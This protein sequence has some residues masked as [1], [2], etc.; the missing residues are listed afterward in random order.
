MNDFEK[1]NGFKPMAIE[2]E[3]GNEIKSPDQIRALIKQNH[4]NLQVALE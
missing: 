4:G 1:N 3:E 2:D